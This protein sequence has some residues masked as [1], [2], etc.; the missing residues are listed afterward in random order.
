MENL[1]ETRQEVINF[2]YTEEFVHGDGRSY[3]SGDGYGSGYG[4]GDGYG[5]GYGRGYGSGY[6]RGDGYGSCYGSGDGYGRGDGYGDGSDVM[7]INGS[8]IHSIDD[9][10]TIIDSVHGSY[11]R[12]RIVGS[13]LQ[14]K[15][16]YIAKCGNF[17]A[18][19]ETLRQAV[20]DAKTKYK[21]NRP[22]E[23]RIA[24]FVT[25]FPTL[26]TNVSAS[27]LFDWHHILTGSCLM[28]R[29]EWCRDNNI[30]MTATYTVGK[31]IELTLNAYGGDAIRELSKQYK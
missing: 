31:F 27:E 4:R 14:M 13:D 6:G 10:I 1:I 28:G 3:G 22:L 24:D 8:I 16:C 30:D 9:I 2:L 7:S 5:S 20:A 23:D 29:Q 12:G 21:E 15:R 17:F 19:G 11:A 25:K 18:H 26:Q